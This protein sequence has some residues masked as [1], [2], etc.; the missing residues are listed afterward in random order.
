MSKKI[1]IKDI[2]EELK[3]SVTTVSFVING[4]AKE[5]NISQAVTKK[6][7]DLVQEWGYQP[8]S[9]AKSLR[10]GKSKIIGFL[11]DDISEPFFSRIAR[12][13]D[14]KASEHG[15][16][17]LFSSTRNN[18]EKAKELLQ[19][20]RDRHVDGYVIALPE[21]LESEIE[22]LIKTEAPVVLFDRY[23]QG[24]ETDYVLTDNS[25]IVFEATQHLID[26]G[27]KNIG[28]VTIETEQQQMLDRL[29]GYE[30]AV[31]SNKQTSLIKKIKYKNSDNMIKEMIDFFKTEEQLD[32]VIFAANYICM[33]GLRTFKEMNI[34]PF[35][36]L[37]VISFDDFELLEFYSPPITAI[38]Q[39]INDIAENIMKTL[40]SR[41]NNESD[42]SQKKQIVLPATLNIR[43]SSLRK[44]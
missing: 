42:K 29:S 39:P 30:Q 5:K 37:A 22:K 36:D 33:D 4:K 35:D 13:I 2:A 20:F 43:S 26:N 11:V 17:I 38:A 27:Y 6:I 31:G 12:L 25:K 15:Y 9:L 34:K 16:K 41:L 8:N 18:T 40:L 19:I 32:A 23:V 14:E 1:K 44:T 3:I 10:T 28:F 21:G 24:M 7:L